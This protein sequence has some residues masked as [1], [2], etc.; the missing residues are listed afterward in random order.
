MEPAGR[1]GKMTLFNSRFLPNNAE[2]QPDAR[3]ELQ[4]LLEFM[5]QSPEKSIRI[6]GHTN[7]NVF[8]SKSWLLDLS[9]YRA[10]AVRD[11]LTENG[12]ASQRIDR[13]ST[14]LNSSH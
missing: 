5:Q 2:F 7:S 14:R 9:V 6:T 10:A 11:F 8:T 4:R 13:K 1:G 3:P 12:V